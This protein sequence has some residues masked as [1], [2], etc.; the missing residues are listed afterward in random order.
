[1]CISSETEQF[2]IIEFPLLVTAQILFS[3]LHMGKND[4]DIGYNVIVVRPDGIIVIGIYTIVLVSLKI[5]IWRI[6]R[7][8]GIYQ[9]VQGGK[10]DP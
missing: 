1:M 7:Q 8:I 9:Q 10:S 3:L 2:S 4:I 6:K 5:R